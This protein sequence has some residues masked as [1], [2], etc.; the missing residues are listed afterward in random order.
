MKKLCHPMEAQSSNCWKIADDKPMD[1]VIGNMYRMKTSD[2]IPIGTT[3]LV[4]FT[5]KTDYE[6]AGTIHAG[7]ACQLV[8]FVRQPQPSYGPDHNWNYFLILSGMTLGWLIIGRYS[9]LEDSWD[10]YFE[11]LL[12]PSLEQ[13]EGIGMSCS[14]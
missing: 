7:D 3:S 8:D 1:L 5:T 4:L 9:S 6:R 14:R 13:E 10:Y 12:D 2:K 11:E